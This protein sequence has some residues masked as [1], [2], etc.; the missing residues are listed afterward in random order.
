MTSSWGLLRLS[1]SLLGRS[2]SLLG[3]SWGGL[4]VS[5]EPLG[6]S[7]RR[8]KTT[9]SYHAKPDQ[10][11]DPSKLS[12]ILFWGVILG[13]KIGQNGIQNESKFKTMFKSEKVALQEPLG[14][15]L[16]RSWAPPTSQ[17]VLWPTRRS[18]F[19]NS[20]FCKQSHLEA[21][22]GLQK[23]ENYPKM[24]FQNDPN[25]IKNRY[26]K[27]IKILSDFKMSATAFLG[28]PGGLRG[29]LGGKIGG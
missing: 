16:G 15:V 26:K 12:H 25:S 19:E 7:W 11:S 28:W 22:L 3:R 6:P 17:I 10:L 23:G 4:G 1:W 21:Q 29:A 27:T 13:A 5:W 20:P 14:A 18:F 9:L 2:W 8:S 24:A